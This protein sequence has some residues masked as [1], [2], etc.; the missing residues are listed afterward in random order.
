[1][2]IEGK[3]QYSVIG[4]PKRDIL[5]NVKIRSTGYNGQSSGL[6]L[7]ELRQRA[8]KQFMQENRV[9]LRIDKY[10]DIEYTYSVDAN[11]RE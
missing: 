5:R 10:K 11:L 6:A 1:M 4:L 8:F 7:R 9:V 3:T 2:D